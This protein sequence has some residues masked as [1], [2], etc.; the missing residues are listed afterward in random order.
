[1]I[2]ELGQPIQK[3]HANERLEI[4]CAELGDTSAAV[5]GCFQP[6][7]RHRM[8]ARVNLDGRSDAISA[9]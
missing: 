6:P 2:N 4:L 1:M 7:S 5:A 8:G 9:F 3:L